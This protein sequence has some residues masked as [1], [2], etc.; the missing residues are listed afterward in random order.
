MNKKA[1]TTFDAYETPN[2]PLTETLRDVRAA[3]RD[4]ALGRT[5]DQVETWTPQGLMPGRRVRV[6]VT[7][8]RI[9]N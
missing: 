1:T 2:L 7:I 5:K 6:T 3:I 9:G 4:F 8:E